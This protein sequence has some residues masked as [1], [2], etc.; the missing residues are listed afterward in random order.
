MCCW[1]WNQNFKYE[2]EMILEYQASKQA[3][4]KERKQSEYTIVIPSI[5]N[6]INNPITKEATDSKAQRNKDLIIL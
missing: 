2:W 3:R 1:M 5:G 6:W 4:K